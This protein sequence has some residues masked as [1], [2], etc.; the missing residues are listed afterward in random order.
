MKIICIGRNYVKHV[1]E[2]KNVV[3]KKPAIFLKPDT[4]L[5]DKNDDFKIP[6]FSKNIHHE[7]EIVLKISKEGK[8]IKKE[9]ALNYF[10]EL[11]VGIDFTARD[12]QDELKEKS[13]S[14]EISKAFD[15]A[16]VVGDF[17]SKKTIFD[18]KDINFS[19]TKNSLVVQKGSTKEMIFDFAFIIS[20]IS[21]YFTLKPG[22]LIFTGTP[23]GVAKVEKND[24][25]KGFLETN[26][27]FELK[28]K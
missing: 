17:V 22:D 5:L 18:L 26:K 2:L 1:E 11:S 9:E 7:I 19:L 25:L 8:N 23:Q 12:I 28:V 6:D 27:L 24:V 15:G 20:Y 14:W 13:L 21:K 16:A 10:N 3:A 4:A